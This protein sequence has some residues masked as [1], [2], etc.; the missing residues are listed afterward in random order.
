MTATERFERWQRAFGIN[1]RDKRIKP[2][3]RNDGVLCLLGRYDVYPV[4]EESRALAR[5]AARV[6]LERENKR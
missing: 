1:L 3:I 5:T 2:A 6:I 4:A